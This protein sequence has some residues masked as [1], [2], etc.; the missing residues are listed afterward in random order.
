VQGARSSALIA[1]WRSVVTDS[2][3]E[4]F[5]A[6][7]ATP[8]Q[9][10][11]AVLT[12]LLNSASL[13]KAAARQVPTHVLTSVEMAM[14]STGLTAATATLGISLEPQGALLIAKLSLTTCATEALR[15]LLTSAGQPPPYKLSSHA[16]AIL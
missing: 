9:V 3:S 13:A 7:T 6:T 14:L 12:A 10:T 16:A 11:D 4:S 8:R 1:A 5:N 15:R 2:T